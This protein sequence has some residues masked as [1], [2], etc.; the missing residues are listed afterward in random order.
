[1]DK[2]HLLQSL[3]RNDFSEHIINAFASV[4]R[5]DF[6][7][8]ELRDYSYEDIALPIGEG[9][10]ISQPTTIAIMLSLLEVK[11]NQKVLEIGSGSGYVLALLSVLVGKKGEVYGIERIKSLADGSKK[12]LK[13]NK[14]IA[15]YNRDGFEGLE[16]HAPFDRIL[17]SAGTERVPEK[18]IPQ[19]KNN[20]ILVVPIG[21]NHEKSMM[22]F[23]KINDELQLKKEIPGF[24]FVPLIED[25]IKIKK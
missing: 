10:T 3:K 19:L 20:G 12:I 11:R 5:E 24:A 14:N 9:Q 2:S 21:S 8:E 16:E 17:I 6:L 4:E 15:V 25:K 22:Q 7:P 1:M 13:K 18:L 23:K